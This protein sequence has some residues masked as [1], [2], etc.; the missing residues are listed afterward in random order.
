[1]HNEL[2]RK[3]MDIPMLHPHHIPANYLIHTN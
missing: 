2:K 3:G 1:M